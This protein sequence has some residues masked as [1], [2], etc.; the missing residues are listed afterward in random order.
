MSETLNNTVALVTGA[1]SGIGQATALRLATSGARVALAGRNVERLKSVAEK[2]AAAGGEAFPIEV[3]LRTSAEAERV[4]SQT[5]DRFG[6]LDTHYQ[7]C[8]RHAQR[9]V[10]QESP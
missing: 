7:C 1:S 8:W 6:R 3:D 2:I 10:H 9:P 5:V 4:V